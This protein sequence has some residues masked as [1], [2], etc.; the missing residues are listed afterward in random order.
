MLSSHFSIHLISVPVDFVFLFLFLYVG[1]LILIDLL[2]PL[3]FYTFYF[4]TLFV[5]KGHDGEES[6]KFKT[7]DDQVIEWLD[8]AIE[9]GAVSNIEMGEVFLVPSI[10]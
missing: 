2:N 10:A 1:T 5:K 7:A 3:F 8:R 6:F 9:M 4:S